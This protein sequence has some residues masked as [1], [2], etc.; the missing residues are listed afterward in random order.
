MTLFRLSCNKRCRTTG[1]AVQGADGKRR[2][3]RH[4]L[5]QADQRLRRG[6]A[7][8]R[9]RNEQGHAARRKPRGRGLQ[10]RRGL[11]RRAAAAVVPGARGGWASPPSR[12]ATHT[13]TV[14]AAPPSPSPLSRDLAVSRGQ[15]QQQR[16]APRHESWKPTQRTHRRQ[17]P[18]LPLFQFRFCP[19]V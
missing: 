12:S 17:L 13:R 1:V 18:D 4:T 14:E 3:L 16:E 11:G 2:V 7:A 9:Q 15:P 8:E 19:S 6:R 5:R 10:A